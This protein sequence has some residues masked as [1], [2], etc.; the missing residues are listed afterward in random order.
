MTKLFSHVMFCQGSV[1][2]VQ[3]VTIFQAFIL[4][5]LLVW[6]MAENNFTHLCFLM[7]VTSL[8]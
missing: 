1:L 8:N 3:Q 4:N 7:P 6:A 2:D 5:A